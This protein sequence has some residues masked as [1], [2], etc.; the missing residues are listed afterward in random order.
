MIMTL[1][2][3]DYPL[4]ATMRAIEECQ[5]KEGVY[6]EKVQ[7]IVDTSKMLYY[8]AK[9]GS[10]HAGDPFRMSLAEWLDQIELKDANYLGQVL[11]GIVGS[12][13]EEKDGKKKG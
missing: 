9:H 6:L 8:F 10:R 4:R 3:K 12:D 5:E 11:Q 7:G 13:E 2:G 1:C